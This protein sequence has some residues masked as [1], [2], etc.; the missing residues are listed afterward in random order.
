MTSDK[1][2]EEHIW[3]SDQNDYDE[4]QITVLMIV[5]YLI[6]TL[7]YCIS[8]GVQHHIWGSEPSGYDKN[9]IDQFAASKFLW[10]NV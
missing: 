5:V 6:K 2:C 1:Y 4:N 8:L 7:V 9:Q 3:G 10:G